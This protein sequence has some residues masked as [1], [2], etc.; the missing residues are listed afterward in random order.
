MRDT[1]RQNS[2]LFASDM[3]MHKATSEVEQLIL[4]LRELEARFETTSLMLEPAW[5]A[6]KGNLNLLR[7]VLLGFQYAALT[8]RLSSTKT[9]PS[10]MSPQ[11]EQHLADVKRMSRMS[12]LTA[13]GLISPSPA[14]STTPSVKTRLPSQLSRKPYSRKTPRRELKS[15]TRHQVDN[16]VSGACQPDGFCPEHGNGD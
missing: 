6:C 3:L 8:G 12:A 11:A 15:P 9:S 13:P 16:C 4:T 14:S 2:K 10:D 1:I 7:Y 5:T